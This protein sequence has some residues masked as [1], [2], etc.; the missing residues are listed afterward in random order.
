MEEG[1]RRKDIEG[2]ENIRN[3]FKIKVRQIKVKEREVRGSDETERRKY[4]P[5]TRFETIPQM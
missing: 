1:G 3:K 4:K 2:Q 5:L